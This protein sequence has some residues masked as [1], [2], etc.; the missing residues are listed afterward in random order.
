MN[1]YVS[2]SQRSQISQLFFK[3]MLI[4][5]KFAYI[6]NLTPIKVL[7]FTVCDNANAN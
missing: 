7:F 4:N 5:V 3:N 2:Y 6:N 1:E